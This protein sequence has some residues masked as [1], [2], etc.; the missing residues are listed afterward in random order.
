VSTNY[1]NK[2]LD[3]VLEEIGIYSDWP[4][5]WNNSQISVDGIFFDEIPG[6]YDWQ[7]FAYL[8]TAQEEVKKAPGLGQQV[9][10]KSQ[11]HNACE[12]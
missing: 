9:I 5:T 10:G 8:K 4:T 11:S 12:V 3:D 7:K 2:G 6:L 1:T